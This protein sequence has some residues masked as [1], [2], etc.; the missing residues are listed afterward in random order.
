[1]GATPPDCAQGWNWPC[2]EHGQSANGCNGGLGYLPCAESRAAG[3]P[4][5]AG[6]YPGTAI[7]LGYA[8]SLDLTRVWL[9]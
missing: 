6:P 1:M 7:W 2:P 9:A 5:I 3:P 8:Q 4:R